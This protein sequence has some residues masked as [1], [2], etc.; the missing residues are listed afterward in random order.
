M[1]SN[2]YNVWSISQ[3]A[4]PAKY[5]YGTGHHF[6][7]EQHV[8]NGHSVTIFSSS[9][10]HYMYNGQVHKKIAKIECVDGVNYVWLKSMHYRS[11]HSV[12]RIINWFYFILTFFLI[13]KKK[14]GK[15]DIVILSSHSML[16]IICALW[17]KFKYKA[18]LIV[19]IRDIWPKTLILLSRQSSKNPL[20]LLISFCEKISY[21]CADWIVSTLPNL[22]EHIQEVSPSKV[23]KF[24]CIP[25]G[26][27]LSVFESDEKLDKQFV[28]NFFFENEFRVIYA[29]AIGPSNALDTFINVAKHFNKYPPLKK[30][31]FYILGEGIDKERLVSLSVE[32]TNVTF[33]PRINRTLVQNFLKYGDLMYDS[34]LKSDLYRYGLSRQKWMDYMYASKPIIVS[35]SGY[36]SLINE[37]NCGRFVEAEN[38]TELRKA[39]IEYSQMTDVELKQIGNNG[40][41]YVIMNRTFEKLAFQYEQIFKSLL[42]KKAHE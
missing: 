18:K 37:A 20:I 1:N 22:V 11:A 36:Q 35:Y 8:K 40:R 39:I 24:T 16:P 14:C 38:E 12:K 13:S 9:Y 31:R 30:I 23:I 17:V 34:V 5:G 7:A 15:P 10:N 21:K 41:A 33:V 32:C 2:K 19:E 26:I 3:Y 42:E 28:D 6:L 4:T 25:Q 29:G 27:P